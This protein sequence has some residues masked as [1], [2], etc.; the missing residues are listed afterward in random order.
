MQLLHLYTLTASN[1][2][3][4]IFTL[5]YQARPGQVNGGQRTGET[6]VSPIQDDCSY[7]VH[8]VLDIEMK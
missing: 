3:G 8:Y 7:R 2:M 4:V 1:R 6:L 5:R